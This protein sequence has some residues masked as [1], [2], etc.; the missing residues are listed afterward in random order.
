MPSI[1]APTA[2]ALGSIPDGDGVAIVEVGPA[3]P[4]ET[5]RRDCN[6]AKAAFEVA[7]QRL[8]LANSALKSALKEGSAKQ[9][10]SVS[11][12]LLCIDQPFWTSFSRTQREEASEEDELEEGEIEE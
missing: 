12:D 10:G 7:K 11:S 3:D 6:E 8:D 5:L 4:F 9:P 2:T 1:A